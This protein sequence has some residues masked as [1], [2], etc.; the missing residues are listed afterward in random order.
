M[1]LPVEDAE[2]FVKCPGRNGQTCA[3][4]SGV[5]RH[6]QGEVF[7]EGKFNPPI[8]VLI[9]ILIVIVR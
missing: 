9:D 1:S 2:D 4:V 3:K 5:F 6:E 8:S 7:L